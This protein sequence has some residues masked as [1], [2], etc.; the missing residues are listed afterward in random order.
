MKKYLLP[1]LAFTSGLHAFCQQGTFTLKGSVKGMD[2][3]TLYL[4][5]LTADDKYIRDS[6]LVQNGAFEFKGNLKEPVQAT[7]S[8]SPNPQYDSPGYA[9]LFLESAAMTATIDGGNFKDM[10]VQG[11]ATQEEYAV[12]QKMEEPVRK[13]Q[14]PAARAYD[15]ANLAYSKARR[16]NLPQA[17]QDSLKD[18]ADALH[19]KLEPY[20]ERYRAISMDFI[21]A[22]PDSYVA[23]S[24]LRGL[25][26]SL[27]VTSLKEIYNNFSDRVKKSS[28]GAKIQKEL[29]ELEQG[30][31]GSMATMFHKTDIKGQP[32]NLADY[33]GK[34]IILIDFWASWCAPCRHSN[35][36]LLKLYAKYKDKGLEIVCVSDDDNSPDAWKKAVAQDGTGAWKHVLR[37]FK[38]T[39]TG[40][41]DTTNDISSFYG[42][43]TLPTKILIDKDGRIIG[44]YGGG[45][46]NDEAMDKKLE[47]IFKS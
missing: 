36:H 1:M 47:E 14:E 37:G 29:K 31:P 27:S 21:K 5:Y 23:A 30:S 22:H 8:N 20:G 34:K 16:D 10:Q 13:D 28:Y 45:G 25:V 4:G 19:E 24:Q 38:M 6:A 35:P 40:G 17:R 41:F 3:G 42:I 18:I 32:F 12:L 9:S 46:E 44:R 43:H 26:S 33:K 15:E 39:K 7:I 11:S 2:K